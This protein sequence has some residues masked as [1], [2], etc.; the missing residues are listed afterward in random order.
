MNSLGQF[1]DSFITVRK[2][3]PEDPELIDVSSEAALRENIRGYLLTAQTAFYR[4]DLKL[5]QKSL[6]RADYLIKRY[7]DNGD[8]VVINTREQIKAA[9]APVENVTPPTHLESQV[10]MRSYLK[11]A[12]RKEQ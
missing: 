11:I 3:Q 10:T 2:K 5:F 4:G 1:M 7:F 6:I 12:E 8:K 9:L